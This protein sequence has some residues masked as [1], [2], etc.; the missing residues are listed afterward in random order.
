MFEM[1]PG[2]GGQYMLRTLVGLSITRR[3]PQRG[4]TASIR[5][6]KAL[7]SERLII[8]RGFAQLTARWPSYTASLGSVNFTCTS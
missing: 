1:S 3:R 6:S 2:S 4:M 5:R 8:Q 7:H